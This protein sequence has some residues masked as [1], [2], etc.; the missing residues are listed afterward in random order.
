MDLGHVLL[1]CRLFSGE[2]KKF[3]QV[4]PLPVLNLGEDGEKTL[5][6]PVARRSQ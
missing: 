1:C 2:S 3:L 4:E 6:E 5:A